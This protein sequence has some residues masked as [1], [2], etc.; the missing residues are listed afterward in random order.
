M[1]WIDP[2][3]IGAN[4]TLC[5]GV[6]KAP[7]Q[8]FHPVSGL[9]GPDKLDGLQNIELHRAG[10]LSDQHLPMQLTGILAASVAVDDQTRAQQEARTTI[11]P[12]WILRPRN[13]SDGQVIRL[14]QAAQQ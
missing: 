1:L 11:S 3:R 6:V 12:R 10:D 2:G 5:D 14:R 7:S 8:P 4:Q 9:H 13:R